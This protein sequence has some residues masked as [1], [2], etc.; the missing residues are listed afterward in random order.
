PPPTA[1]DCHLQHVDEYH[2]AHPHHRTITNY[3]SVH[4]I[5]IPQRT[6]ST[7]HDGSHC[8]FSWGECRY[9][10]G[11]LG[12][13]AT[14]GVRSLRAAS[15]RRATTESRFTPA[16]KERVEVSGEREGCKL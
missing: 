16:E 12:T 15:L 1:G 10:D 9:E 4:R 11:G 13:K 5:S 6:A 7:S 14:C 3:R 2:R 8:R